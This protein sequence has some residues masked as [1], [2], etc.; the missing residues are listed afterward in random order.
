MIDIDRIAQ[1]ST[2]VYRCP[3]C[4]L[5]HSVWFNNSSTYNYN[6]WLYWICLLFIQFAKRSNHLVDCSPAGYWI[7]L[8][9]PT[10]WISDIDAFSKAYAYKT[11]CLLTNPSVSAE[12]STSLSKL[13]KSRLRTFCIMSFVTLIDAG[14][15]D[16]AFPTLWFVAAARSRVKST[17]WATLV[18]ISSDD[19]KMVLA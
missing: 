11:A 13:S 3:I 4:H 18:C 8:L 15:S 17:A 1:Y 14:N 2:S 19:E 10:E 6:R 12:T 7:L 16:S 5:Q 9:F